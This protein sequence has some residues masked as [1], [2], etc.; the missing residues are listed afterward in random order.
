MK[1]KKIDTNLDTVFGTTRKKV[2]MNVKFGLHH[3]VRKDGT[4]LIYIII[5]PGRM[6]ISTE[7][8]VDVNMW[9]QKKQLVKGK[10]QYSYNTNI[11]L[12]AI[13]QKIHHIITRYFVMNLFLDPETLVKEYKQEIIDIDFNIYIKNKLE[14]IKESVSPGTYTNYSSFHK[15][16]IKWKPSILFT[17]IDNN[18]IKEFVHWCKYSENNS[19][20][21]INSNLMTLKRFVSL[22]NDDNIFMKIKSNDIHT[23]A[24]RGNVYPLSPEETMLIY[25]NWK[26]KK[27]LENEKDAVSIFL[28]ACFMGL[29]IQDILEFDKNK[30]NKN[31]YIF[32]ATKTYKQHRIPVSEKAKEILRTIELPYRKVHQSEL[33]RR[34]KIF[35][36]RIGIEKDFSF[37]TGRHTFA[38]NFIIAGGS[39][40]I[41]KQILGHTS[42]HTTMIYLTFA[43]NYARKEIDQMDDFMSKFL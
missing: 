28:I 23:K 37:H 16:L 42:I 43:N 10:T 19:Q 15:K 36:K 26:N 3:R 7:I 6:R 34:L 8:S 1:L 5:N 18:F 11:K 27:Y 4:S 25:R 39:I 17:E 31:E 22:A 32:T 20:I 29:R 12:Q 13:L 14:K 24:I 9:D 2:D 33:R 35:C 30:I 38:T 40:E 21:T 41:L